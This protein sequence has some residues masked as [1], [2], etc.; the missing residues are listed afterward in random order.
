MS[1]IGLAIILSR[2]SV[3]KRLLFLVHDLSSLQCLLRLKLHTV[4]SFPKGGRQGTE[5]AGKSPGDGCSGVFYPIRQN[6]RLDSV[7]YTLSHFPLDQ[8]IPLRI[9]NQI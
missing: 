6:Q 1:A 9:P 8:P 7:S 4:S 3:E 2:R 5:Q